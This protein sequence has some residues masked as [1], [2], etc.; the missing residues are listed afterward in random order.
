VKQINKCLIDLEQYVLDL[1]GEPPGD[2]IGFV[3]ELKQ[4]P[5]APLIAYYNTAEQ[6]REANRQKKK[7]DLEEDDIYNSEED[8]DS[9]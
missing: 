5:V 1:Y 8:E 7:V 3:S 9:S 4:V 6:K 2:Q